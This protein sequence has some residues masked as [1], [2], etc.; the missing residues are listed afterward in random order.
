MEFERR[1]AFRLELRGGAN[2]YKLGEIEDR[3]LLVLDMASFV[4]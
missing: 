2:T 1:F 3:R 4:S